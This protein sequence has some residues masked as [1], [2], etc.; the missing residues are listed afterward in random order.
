MVTRM[1]VVLGADCW[2]SSPWQP[3][4]SAPGNLHQV[5]LATCTKRTWQ[6]APGAP[7]NLHQVHLAT[8]TKCTWLAPAQGGRPHLASLHPRTCQA[9][10]GLGAIRGGWVQLGAIGAKLGATDARTHQVRLFAPNEQ[11]QPSRLVIYCWVL[12]SY[13]LLGSIS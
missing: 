2:V 8:C 4:P 3:A 1:L 9:R 10:G 13:W 11:N 7:G 6:P 5:H 12:L